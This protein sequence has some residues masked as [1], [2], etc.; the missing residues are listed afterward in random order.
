[1]TP[2]EIVKNKAREFTEGLPQLLTREE[3]A[4][5]LWVLNSQGV[6]PSLSTVLVEEVTRF[7]ILLTKMR[8]SLD[9]LV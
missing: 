2:D 1:L 4:K 5:E 9:E 7:N 3:S 8:S 6:I